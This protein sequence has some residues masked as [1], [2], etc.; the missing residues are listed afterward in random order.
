MR[1]Y[2]MPITTHQVTR[3]RR[4]PNGETQSVRLFTRISSGLTR[5]SAVLL[6]FFLFAVDRYLLNRRGD[7]G[8]CPDSFPVTTSTVHHAELFV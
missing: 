2:G 6:F 4:A 1:S 5:T 8:N 7:F 3:K